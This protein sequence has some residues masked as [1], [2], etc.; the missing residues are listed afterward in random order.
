LD[1]QEKLALMYSI[2]V[3][4]YF[5]TPGKYQ[6][7]CSL[8]HTGWQ[9]NLYSSN[10]NLR[11]QVHIEIKKKPEDLTFPAKRQP[12]VN[13]WTLITTPLSLTVSPL[14]LFI[15]QYQFHRNQ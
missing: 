6:L 4:S 1:K 7:L 13:T 8:L 11:Q 12:P 5:D 3:Q 2:S 10:K 14:S 9:R 15:V